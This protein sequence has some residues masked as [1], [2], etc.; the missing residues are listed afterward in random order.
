MNFLPDNYKE[1]EAPSLYFQKIPEGETR[2]RILDKAQL[3]W[4]GWKD[5]DD[6]DKKGIPVRIQDDNPIGY[7]VDAFENT[8]RD[9]KFIWALPIYN[10]SANCVQLWAI[11]Q[12]TIRDRLNELNRKAS[13]GDPVNYDIIIDRTGTEMSNTVYSLTPEPKEELSADKWA[14]YLVWKDKFDMEKWWEGQDPIKKDDSDNSKEDKVDIDK[15]AK[16]L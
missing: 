6:P 8:I 1:P 3:G 12:K 13:W 2:I 14:D 5:S 16:E 11:S 7:P 15:I 9:I 4:Q 10:Y